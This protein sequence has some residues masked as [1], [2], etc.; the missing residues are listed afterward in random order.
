MEK[1][2]CSL[3]KQAI[4]DGLNK[5][6]SIDTKALL[7]KYPPLA[8]QRATFVTLTLDGRLR[9]CIGSL[10]AHRTLLD[11]LIHNAKSAAFE[12][13]RFYPLSPEEFKKVVIEIS[14][15][16]PPEPLLYDSIE[17]LKSKVSVGIDGIILQKEGKRATF[18][19]QVWEQLPTFEHFFSHLCQKAGLGANCLEY[20]PDIWRYFVEKIK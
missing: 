9:G 1:V 12:D 17:D 15:L 19:P 4:L 20:H 18:L 11:D 2:I 6:Q 14:L 8:Q 3:A 13:P 5:T 7:E 16:S 10:V